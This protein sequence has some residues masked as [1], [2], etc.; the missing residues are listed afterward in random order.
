MK[1]LSLTTHKLRLLIYIHFDEKKSCRHRQD[2]KKFEKVS[3]V[4]S[5]PKNKPE[6]PL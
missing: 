5:P 4:V 1:N 3:D 2:G 6:K